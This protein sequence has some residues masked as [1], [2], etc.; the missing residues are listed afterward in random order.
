MQ[1]EQETVNSWYKYTVPLFG[2]V[3]EKGKKIASEK[4][5]RH[6]PGK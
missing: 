5:V 1:T 6:S 3:S 4:L 2:P